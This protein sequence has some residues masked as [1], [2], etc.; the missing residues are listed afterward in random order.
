MAR[1]GRYL[2]SQIQGS[3][4]QAEEG[5]LIVLAAGD[6]S[7]FD[8]SQTC[9]QAMGKSSFYLGTVFFLPHDF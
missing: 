7:L 3:K 6:K 8:D 9:F 2:E 5:S 4:A 1:G